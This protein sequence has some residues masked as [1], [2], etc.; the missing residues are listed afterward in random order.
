MPNYPIQ[1][2]SF[3][4][5]K[6][7]F[8]LTLNRPGAKSTSEYS[9]FANW[10]GWKFANWNVILSRVANH[11]NSQCV[12]QFHLDGLHVTRRRRRITIPSYVTGVWCDCARESGTVD[13]DDDD[14]WDLALRKRSGSGRMRLSSPGRGCRHDSRNNIIINTLTLQSTH[15]SSGDYRI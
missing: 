5:L 10:M 14:D 15:H 13:N 12:E 8:K 7:V 1:C 4:W 2:H 6:E 3:T 9:L 11:K